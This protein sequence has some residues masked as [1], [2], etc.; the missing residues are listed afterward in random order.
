MN[1]NEKNIY[2][3]TLYE[4]NDIKETINDNKTKKFI[5]Y[6]LK[7]SIILSSSAL[8]QMLKQMIYNIITESV[9]DYTKNFIEKHFLN[10]TINPNSKNVIELINKINANI[11]KKFKSGINKKYSYY[12]DNLNALISNRNTI[13]HT[14]AGTPMSIDEIINAHISGVKLILF[15][16]WLVMHDKKNYQLTRTCINFV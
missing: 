7:Y 16:D 12:R 14:Q 5:T 6:L 3:N 11:S 4:L 9:N 15:L 2:H 13:A 10:K 1:E 8:E